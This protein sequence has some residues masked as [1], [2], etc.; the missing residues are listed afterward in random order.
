MNTK[1][2]APCIIV[3]ETGVKMLIGLP[4]PDFRKLQNMKPI[5]SRPTHP[6]PQTPQWRD[7]KRQKK[8]W[9]KR[10]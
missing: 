8:S 1:D 10:L 2:S 4:K 9:K 5:D 6:P 3:T 7:A